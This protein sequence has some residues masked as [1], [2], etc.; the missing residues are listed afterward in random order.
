MDVKFLLYLSSAIIKF[1]KSFSKA[2]ISS[3]KKSCEMLAQAHIIFE[4]SPS[5]FGVIV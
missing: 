3:F 1:F 2:G 5:A 4:L